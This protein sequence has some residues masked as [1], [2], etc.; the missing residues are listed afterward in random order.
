MGVHWYTLT[1]CNN[2]VTNCFGQFSSTQ[3]IQKTLVILSNKVA[4]AEWMS[5]IHSS[6]TRNVA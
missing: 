1:T 2:I 3:M 4:H 6:K 5:R